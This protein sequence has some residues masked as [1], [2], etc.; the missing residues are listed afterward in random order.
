MLADAE[1]GELEVIV[2]CNGCTDDTAD[3]ARALAHPDIKV[4]ETPVGSKTGAL[5]LGDD[6]ATGFPRFYVDADIE[7]PIRAIREVAR[8]LREHDDILV[9]A[10]QAKVDTRDRP[11]WVR[12]YYTVWTQLPY[13]TE[14]VIGSGVYA[15]SE[16]G[17]ARFDKFPDII[18]DDEFARLQVSPH[19]RQCATG[20]VFTITPPTSLRAIIKINTRVKAGNQQLRQRFPQLIQNDNTTPR[21]TLKVIAGHPPLW[22]HAPIYLGV[23]VAATLLARR[24]LKRQQQTVWDRDDSARE[25]IGQRSE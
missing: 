23:M 16:R 24:K 18:A 15:F 1:P 8:L 5:N 4:L 25:T 3:R 14:G 17:R 19:E 11:W 21:R 9:A 13:F 2:V 12:S 22:P 7:L 6:H 10:P 20:V